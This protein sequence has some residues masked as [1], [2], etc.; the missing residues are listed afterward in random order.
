KVAVFRKRRQ[1]GFGR[2][3]GIAMPALRLQM[4][5]A[6]D[7]RFDRGRFHEFQLFQ[8]AGPPGFSLAEPAAPQKLAPRRMPTTR[9]RRGSSALMNWAVEVQ[10]VALLSFRFWPYSCTYQWSKFAPIDASTVV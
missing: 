9:G 6:N 3:Q 1:A 5:E 8:A 10:V 7:F 4:P 2:C